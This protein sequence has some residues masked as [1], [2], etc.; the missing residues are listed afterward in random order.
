[1]PRAPAP[2][3][4]SKKPA[5]NKRAP[6]VL[7][8]RALEH[9]EKAFGARYLRPGFA[10]TPELDLA[11]ALGHGSAMGPV[12]LLGDLAPGARRSHSYTQIPRNVA[13]AELRVTPK[14]FGAPVPHEASPAPIAEDEA[15]AIVRERLKNLSLQPIHFRAL[16]AMVGPSC[17]LEAYLDG[18]EG[19]DAQPWDT[20]RLVGFFPVLYGLLLR[21]PARESMAARARL[22][23][24]FEKKKMMFAAA[25]LDIALHGRE[26]IARVGYK[27]S[28]TYKSYGR[29]DK[30]E[31]SN[32]VDLCFCDGEPEFV[33]SQFAALWA[34]FK[35]KV[36]AQMNGPSPA[37]LFFLGGEKALETE[38]LVVDHYPGTKQ[39]E[40]L[41]SYAE[42]RSP[43]AARLVLRL[44]AEKSK[45]KP[46]ALEW[47]RTQD[48]AQKLVA[49]W[50]SDASSPDAALAKAALAQLGI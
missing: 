3:E 43:N 19:I 7:A 12:R 20:G 21:T 47:L 41:E 37:R 10:L 22:E 16:E 28:T 13:I 8:S 30:D 39:P 32:V 17:V 40:A 36:Q 44:S 27:Y 45:V 29:S 15:Q 2:R 50:A 33:A 14:Q 11:F 4:K 42:I 46:A 6:E 49:E 18:L 35:F 48:W 5:P 34:A 23:M 24:L 1:M 31:P 25:N 38:L 9:G 26:G